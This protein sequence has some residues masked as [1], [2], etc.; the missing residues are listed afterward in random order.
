MKSMATMLMLLVLFLPNTFAEG[1]T[2]WGLP[3]GAVARLGKGPIRS[4]SFSPDITRVAVS[5]RIGVWFYDTATGK[6][7]AL[8][9]G[10]PGL[11]G[12]VAF[13]PDG[14]MFASGSEDRVYLW[15]AFTGEHK[16]TLT[17]AS[18]TVRGEPG[19]VGGFVFSPD[20]TVL[21]G[22][23]GGWD[24]HTVELWDLM[25][26]EH[27]GTL[28]R[29]T[30]DFTL[31]FSPDGTTLACGEMVHN[32]IGVWDTVTGQRKLAL[33]RRGTIDITSLAFS[34]DDSTIA[35]VKF[36]RGS[37]AT[38]GIPLQANS[39][40][41]IA[42]HV[43]AVYSRGIQPGLFTTLASGSGDGTVRLWHTG[44]GEREGRFT[45]HAKTVSSVAFSP[46]GGT[47]VSASEDSVCLW[48]DTKIKRNWRFTGH[49]ESGSV[50]LLSARMGATLASGDVRLG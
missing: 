24:N 25:S 13:S 23:G 2:Q 36:K 44:T 29:Y 22:G 45:G 4:I 47:L 20:G 50:P 6:E 49:V 34:P 33:T 30:Y 46:D 27:K 18:G 43:D 38:Y 5:S 19:T 42:G 48:A 28:T 31:A 26:G 8:F 39:S 37:G 3:E 16:G 21:A 15:D 14:T 12:G 1:Y 10:P 35:T 17:G 7:T 40:K 32:S 9:A 11:L 41:G